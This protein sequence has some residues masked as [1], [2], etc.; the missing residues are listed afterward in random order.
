MSTSITTVDQQFLMPRLT[1]KRFEDHTIP[2]ELLED[3]AEFESLL[4]EVAK[5]I[6]LK[7]NPDRKRVPRGF[8]DGISLK[9]AAV[10]EGS[11]IPKIILAASLIGLF[12]SENYHYFE[13]AKQD[14]FKTI[15]AAAT[16]KVITEFI[17]E[18]L[19]VYF[20]KIGK[21]LREDETIDFSP[22]TSLQAKLTKTSRK[23]LVLASS[24]INEVTNET[25]LR[26]LIPEA[27]KSKQTFTML[28]ENGQRVVAQMP[29]QYLATILEAFINYEKNCKVSVSGIGR[30]NKY[31]KMESFESIEHIDILDPLDITNRLEEIAL[32]EEGWL[33]GEGVAP[34]KVDLDWFAE[35]FESN[36]DTSL[37][38]P[39]LYPTPQGGLQAEWTTDKYDVSLNID[40]TNKVAV[41]QALNLLTDEADDLKLKLTEKADWQ[42]MN[43]KLINISKA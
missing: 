37:P 26:A 31:D 12:P 39:Y 29:P 41:Y 30:F 4:M 1:G 27:D 35:I 17:P 40:F 28:L 13:K 24:N 11:A 2:L 16:G 42:T 3:F 34:K 7:E 19:L 9:L 21:R 23:K 18:N 15:D 10:E 33:N 36:Y 20:N 43:S 8:A 32:L 25:K 22:N 38:L 6:Y 5:S 14:I